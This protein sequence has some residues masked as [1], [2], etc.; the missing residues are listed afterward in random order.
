MSTMGAVAIWGP[1]VPA[2]TAEV[3]AMA[4]G[5]A[6]GSVR[7]T[8]RG[9]LVRSVLLGVLALALLVVGV[10]RLTAAPARAGAEQTVPVSVAEVVV[11]QGDSL[12][13]IAERV[14]P[15]RD[16]R[17]VI[18]ELRELNGLSS[19]LLQPGQVLLVPSGL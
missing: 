12:W 10:A 16:P 3:P 2:A 5:A 17:D 11:E 9:R 4:G 15:G 8:R 18:H 19:N 1:M 7:L 14:A 13:V 6:Q